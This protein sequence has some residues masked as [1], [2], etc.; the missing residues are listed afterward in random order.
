MKA[1]LLLMTFV[2]VSS[3][4]AFAVAQDCSVSNPCPDGQC[5]S[6]FGFCGCTDAYCG[7]GCQGQCGNCGGGGGGGQFTG[8]ATF[9]TEYV[10]S[11]CYGS[12]QSPFPPGPLIAAASSDLYNNGA[13]C[14]SSYSITCEGAA[15]G[16]S[17]PCT[18]NP[19]VTVKV[20]DLCPGC[21]QNS[22]DLSEQAFAKIANVNAGRLTISARKVSG[23][24]EELEAAEIVQVV[25]PPRDTI[26]NCTTHV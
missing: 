6:Q 24:G 15:S 19:T 1:Q 22:F 23:I 5:C 8:Q 2:V 9:Y 7:S 14:G 13:I 3:A 12:D 25:E 16:G 18:G 10:P 17:N 21:H 11:A 4:V 26:S 20:V